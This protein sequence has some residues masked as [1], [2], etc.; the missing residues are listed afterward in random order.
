MAIDLS[1]FHKFNV[2]DTCSIWNI[3]S[4][5]ILYEAANAAGCHFCLTYFVHYEC[6]Y[7][8]RKS[9]S[10]EDIE[11]KERLQIAIRDQKITSYHLDLEDLQEIDILQQRM[12][13]GKG[14]LASIAFAKK[15]QQAF[16]TDDMK[17]RRLAGEV[18]HR[19]FVQTTPHLVGWLFFKSFF[20][21]S[22][23]QLILD[24]HEKFKRPLAP[25]FT[26]M[27]ETALSYRLKSSSH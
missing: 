27:Y 7:K 8:S 18:M 17:A 9:Y 10:P 14:E 5:R 16:L 21:D 24:E 23:L 3:F 4:S 25:Y 20:G 11:L 2:A 1:H 15:T 13:L 26:E 19:Q 12:K 6:L 22:D